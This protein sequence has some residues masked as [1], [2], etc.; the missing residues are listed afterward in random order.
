MRS[1]RSAGGIS[2]DIVAG[3]D[4]PQLARSLHLGDRLIERLDG[5]GRHGKAGE[6]DYRIDR[7]TIT[8]PSHLVEFLALDNAGGDVAIDERHG[9]CTITPSLQFAENKLVADLDLQAGGPRS[10]DESFQYRQ[11]SGRTEH[12]D[13]LAIQAGAAVE[14]PGRFL[15]GEKTIAG[16][17]DRTRQPKALL[18]F[19]G[20]HQREK[21]V[22]TTELRL[23]EGAPPRQNGN[24]AALPGHAA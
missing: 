21:P 17:R 10:D 19:G 4:G 5:F 23:L 11:G 12:R 14:H 20:R 8:G 7:R 13:R 3:E 6:A 18:P 24:G 2:A 15:H 9:G 1:P 22:D 16:P